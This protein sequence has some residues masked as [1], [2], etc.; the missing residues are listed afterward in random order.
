MAFEVIT[1]TYSS[2]NDMIDA[3]IDAWDFDSTDQTSATHSADWGTM[4]LTCYDQ[5]YISLYLNGSF[6]SNGSIS[7]GS[8]GGT[9]TIYK[10]ANTLLCVVG[11]GALVL[12]TGVSVEDETDTDKIT[13]M[14]HGNYIFVCGGGGLW[15]PSNSTTAVGFVT[16]ETSAVQVFPYMHPYG[17]YKCEDFCLVRVASSNSLNTRMYIG[18]ELYYIYHVFAVKEG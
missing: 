6:V 15:Q 4:R 10:T 12:T 5:T 7:L 2:G 3:L 13:A 16:T 18:D 11:D 9:Y 1:G 8:T 14:I 17:A